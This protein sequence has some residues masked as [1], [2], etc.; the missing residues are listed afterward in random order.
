MA[1]AAN[2][3]SR[4]KCSLRIQEAL[5]SP[6]P[7]RS[8]ISSNMEGYPTRIS[9]VSYPLSLL[10]EYYDINFI[11]ITILT[12]VSMVNPA[13]FRSPPMSRMAAKGDTCAAKPCDYTRLFIVCTGIERVLLRTPSRSVSPSCS[14]PLSSYKVSPPKI[15]A[16]NTPSGRRHF[17]I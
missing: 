3:V 7:L 16:I 1:D 13:P 2:I 17:M 14:E 12:I 10:T 8:A 11:R 5:F 4:C 15:A 9:S 6:I